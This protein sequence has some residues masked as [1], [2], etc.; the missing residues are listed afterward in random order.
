MLPIAL[1]TAGRRALVVGGGNVAAR[2]T[3]ALLDAGLSVTIVAPAIGDEL[4]ALVSDGILERAY[5]AADLDGAD[6][7]I[8]ATDKAEVNA[9]V[10]AD[11]RVARLPVCDA[12]EPD[13]GDFTMQATVRVGELTFTVDSGGSTPAFARRVA[14]ELRERF[15][16]SYDA[17]ARTL[18]RMRVYVQAVLAPD[19]RAAVLRALSALPVEEL[20]SLNPVQAEHLVE[21][22]IEKLRHGAHRAPA[23]A[24][25]VCASRASALAMTQARM[26]AARLAQ[27]G[28]A[29]TILNVSTTGD[30][31]QDRPVSELGSVNVWVKELEVALAD[32][33][34]DYAVHSCKDLPGVLADGM[35]LAAISV[36]EDPRD[37]FCSERYARF[38]DLPPGARVG[39]S[40]Q[41]RRAQLH[42]LRPELNYEDLR[43]NVDTRLRKLREG[44]YEAIV[45]AMAGLNRLGVR[46]AHTV[47][48]DPQTLVPAVGQGALAVETLAGADALARDLHACV[49]DHLTHL[50]I[51]AER[52]ALRALRAGCSAPLGVHARIE[53]GTMTID[54]AFGTPEGTLLRERCVEQV[55]DADGARAAGQRIARRLERARGGA[56]PHVVLPRTQER[57]SRIAATLRERGVEVTEV[58]EGE[59]DPTLME[60]IPDMLLFPSSGAVEALRPYLDWLRVQPRRP[61]VAAMGPQSGAAAAQAGFVPD[62]VAH[63]AG[64]DAFVDAV[65]ARLGMS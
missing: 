46:A 15:G 20:A 22:T 14:G 45:L 57:Q 12:I 62:V 33:R 27:R 50:C 4:R 24:S 38:E 7:V 56:P 23:R 40:S 17:A 63:E 41:R 30:R 11:A 37:A 53:D 1:R 13:R 29:T 5:Q 8:A 16:P 35:H 3:Q 18:A 55:L 2:K 31:V 60:T 51:E 48:F 34:A 39:T 44:Q 54:A 25:V 32:G 26:V 9:R 6:L 10:V 36:R 47:P 19:E 61:L 59:A 52:A 64:V 58:R 43:G 49:D 28:I 65:I 42:A 21:E